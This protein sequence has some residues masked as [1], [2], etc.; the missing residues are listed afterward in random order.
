LPTTQRRSGRDEG[1]QRLK[2]FGVYTP[3]DVERFAKLYF[4]RTATQDRLYAQLGSVVERFEELVPDEK[5]EFR[6]QLT[7]YA[8]LYAF[9]SQV[10]PFTDTDLEKLY[11]FVRSLRRLLP[12]PTDQ[13]PRE[14][15]RKI[16][17]DSYRIQ[18]TGSG[19]IL[20]ESRNG[21]LHPM[22]TKDAY[23]LAEED[24]EPLSLI[25]EELN[26][27]FGL[28][29]GPEHKVTLEQ[30]MD[31]LDQDKALDASAR[32]NTRENVRLTFDHK[33]E[34]VI[35]EIVDTNFE[36]YKRITDNQAFGEALKTFLFDQY[37]RTHRHADELLKQH[38]SKTLEFKSTLRWNL[39]ED[40]KDPTV[41]THAV[42]KTIAAFLNTDGGDLLIGVADD[43]SIVGIEED[44]FEDDDNFLLH[45]S[46]VIGAALG[47]RAGTLVD[48]K[49]ETVHGK[50]VCLVSC[51]RSPAPVYFKWRSMEE[52]EEGDFYVRSGPETVTLGPA[53]TAKYIQTR[54]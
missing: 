50:T 4:S 52:Y 29:L 20:L 28:N 26:E 27:R 3:D 12:A 34:D 51:Q 43:K 23:G 19:K 17:I 33:V 41:V 22:S 16:D 7:D 36:L 49:M 11:V 42:L 47:D 53:D 6:R 9:L 21:K 25:I 40:R 14:V 24:L 54:F 31:R 13:L 30:M 46:H 45:L 15:Q 39:R 35:Q 1:E 32:V 38:E 48:A 5:L 18:K 37:V 2:D 44:R 8:R 10:L